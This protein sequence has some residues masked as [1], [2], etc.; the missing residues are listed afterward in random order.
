MTLATRKL[1]VKGR[2]TEVLTAGDGEPLVFLHGGG[3]V[4]GFEF[5][6]PLTDRFWVIAPL[7]PGY[8]E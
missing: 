2:P 4:E 3:I 1:D 6:E 8:A 5:L 7:R